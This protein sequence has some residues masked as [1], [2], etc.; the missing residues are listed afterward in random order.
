MGVVTRGHAGLESFAIPQ[1]NTRGKEGRHL[2]QEEVR[3]A[4]DETRSCK[5]VGMRQQGA[6][7]RLEN[8][9]E[10]KGTWTELW[11]T[12]PHRIKSLIQAVYDVLPSPSNLHI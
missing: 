11:R 8:A 4:V 1:T 6:W 9:V 5:A 2:L 10:R 3:A 12:E 7:T